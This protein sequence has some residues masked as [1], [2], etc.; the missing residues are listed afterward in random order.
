MFKEDRHTKRHTL[1]R[2]RNEMLTSVTF[3]QQFG[4]NMVQMISIKING[5]YEF[6]E[7]QSCKSHTFLMGVHAFTAILSKLIVQFV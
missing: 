2:D 1:L 5:V 7:N 6:D 3:F 4:K